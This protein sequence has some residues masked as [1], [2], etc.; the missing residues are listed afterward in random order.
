MIAAG[1]IERARSRWMIAGLAAAVAP[2]LALA[3]YAYP[4]ADDFDY[5]MDTRLQGYWAALSHQYTGWNGRFASNLFVLANPVLTGS[6]TVYHLVAA[7]MFV[8]TI[9]AMYTFIRAAAGSALDRRTAV[10]CAVAWC[11]VY[12]AGVPALAESFYW[13][14]GA[15]TYQLS[16]ALLLVQVSLF[17]R[18]LMRQRASGTIA[19]DLVAASALLFFVV[20]MNEIAMLLAIAFYAAFAAFAAIR[21]ERAA[22]RA[23]FVS[24]GTAVLAG[25]AVWLAPGNA[26]RAGFYSTRH[27]LIRS[28]AMTIVQ[29]IRFGAAWATSGTL[30]LATIVFLPVAVRIAAAHAFWRRLPRREF[31]AFLV[32][33]FAAIPIGLF[34]PFWATGLL[35]QHRTVSVA[36]S[37]F[38][39]LWFVAVVAVA[40]RNLIPAAATALL[41]P[42]RRSLASALLLGLAFTG[43]G[44]A[45]TTDL[46]TGRAR[47]FAA[48]MEARSAALDE[49]RRAPGR[50][51]VIQPLSDS[52]RALYM[53]DGGAAAAWTVQSYARYFGVS[54]VEIRPGPGSDDVRH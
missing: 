10:V 14:T 39:A 51:C 13:Y 45:V 32:A 31:I 9:G 3:A 54:R 18:I 24:L 53:P 12:V 1:G 4:T 8:V 29:T 22:A 33:P 36:Y 21:G 37:A 19:R 34:P 48:A 47:R 2:Y 7:A 25:L 28:V 17:L 46:L 43:N 38:L 5:A 27:E 16:C 20:G 15:I 6:V 11:G 49:C 44:Y 41:P 40:G 52:P 42:V 50:P 23:A 35:G 26:V 30:L